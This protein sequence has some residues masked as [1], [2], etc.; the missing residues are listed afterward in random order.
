MRKVIKKDLKEYLNGL[1]EQ[2][3]VEIRD[4]FLEMTGLSYPSWYNKISGR[5]SFSKL[6]IATLGNI[7][8]VQFVA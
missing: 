7:C 8:K 2:E 4:T 3:R 1:S 6:E 5:C